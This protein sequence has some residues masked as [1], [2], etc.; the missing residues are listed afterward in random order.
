MVKQREKVGLDPNSKKETQSKTKSFENLP[1]IKYNGF[2]LLVI[3]L[4]IPQIVE[5]TSRSTIISKRILKN[6]DE[7]CCKLH[8]RYG[9][10]LLI[11]NI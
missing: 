10:T 1:V 2:V 4:P 9:G 5:K 3:S 6:E 8:F 7:K 11:P